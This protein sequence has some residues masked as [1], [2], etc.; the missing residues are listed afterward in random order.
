[1]SEHEDEYGETPPK[2]GKKG[3]KGTKRARPKKIS[4]R[5]LQ[6]EEQS[7]PES[8]EE[9]K[10]MELAGEEEPQQAPQ[11]EQEPEQEEE[12]EEMLLPPEPAQFTE[13]AAPEEEQ[14]QQQAEQEQQ[15]AEQEQQPVEPET[16]GEEEGLAKYIFQGE[17]EQPTQA[18]EAEKAE[19]G[20]AMAP[21]SAPDVIETQ[22]AEAPP[23]AEPQP[24]E[25]EE[26]EEQQEEEQQ[27]EEQQEEEP[28]T[29]EPPPATTTTAAPSEAE[30]IVEQGN[31]LFLYRPKVGVEEASSLS[32]FQR[33]YMI[34][35]PQAADRKPRL[36]ILG[37]KRLPKVSG[38]ERFFGFID[39]VGDSVESLTAELGPK[40]YETKTRGTR[41]V[42]AA[43]AAGEATYAIVNLGGSGAGAGR[44]KLVLKLIVPQQPG[45]VQED[46]AIPQEGSYAFSI[47]NPKNEPRYTQQGGAE[48]EAAGGAGGGAIGLEQKADYAPEQKKEFGNYAWIG[49]TDPS[50]LEYERSEFL[51]V[52]TR[53]AAGDEVKGREECAESDEECLLEEMKK[54]MTGDGNEDLK[55]EVQPLETGEWK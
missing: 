7:P 28:K 13:A 43:R 37:K 36:A 55:V 54:E 51:L 15:P 2:R 45:E 10:K 26:E 38:H 39:A 14:Q 33:F 9:A 42:A 25:E 16:Q 30:G 41:Q 23:A 17:E 21:P 24:V 29:E 40:S 47:K 8:E 19:E 46:F 18:E 1:M 27:E 44:T 22:Q 6:H 31:L 4:G 20:G 48:G 3:K 34:F 53:E 49:C 52:G 5:E 32:E 11:Q 50:L 12:E 35:A